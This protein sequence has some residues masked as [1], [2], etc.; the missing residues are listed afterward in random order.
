M[1]L[2]Y[3]YRTVYTWEPWALYV[4]AVLLL[5]AGIGLFVWGR[6]RA[7]EERESIRAAEAAAGPG[8]DRRRTLERDDWRRLRRWE[9]VCTAGIVAA[10]GFLLLGFL[11]LHTRDEAHVNLRDNLKAR[12]GAALIVADEVEAVDGGYLVELHWR[13][14]EARP[15]L[16]PDVYDAIVVPD[17]L[18]TVEDRRVPT[19][20]QIPPE[21][22]AEY[23]ELSG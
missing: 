13:R 3:G 5:V 1:V 9:L 23:P 18:V 12:Y 15:D 19:A 10:C 14:P 21:V 11:G 20:T 8:A 6:R 4:G 22:L 17:V 7:A 16:A 2:V